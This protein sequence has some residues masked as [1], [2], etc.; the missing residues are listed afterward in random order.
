MYNT[1]YYTYIY[2]CLPEDEPS[3]LKHT[4]DQKL[5]IIFNLEKVYV[6]ALCCIIMVVTVISTVR[7]CRFLVCQIVM[8]SNGENCNMFLLRNVDVKA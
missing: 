7:G 3:G 5:K 6:V 2:I 1:L 8:P 4:E